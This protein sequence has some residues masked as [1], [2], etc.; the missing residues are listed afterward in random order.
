MHRCTVLAVGIN[1]QRPA[2]LR[3]AYQTTNYHT[4]YQHKHS[5][6]AS[7]LIYFTVNIN[8]G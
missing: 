8:A 4:T 6:H 3:H 5:T 1:D 7:A 2:M